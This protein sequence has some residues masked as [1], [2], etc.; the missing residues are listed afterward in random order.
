MRINVWKTDHEIADTVANSLE[1][2]LHGFTPNISIGY[3]ILRGNA[4]RI[5]ECETK[6]ESYFI[7][8]RGYFKP[9]H[10]DGY[11]RIS[12][13]G[14]QQTTGL[15]HIQP[16][17]ERLERLQID[18]PTPCTLT[19]DA[20]TL[21]VPP[22]E[23]A[24]EFFLGWD[25]SNEWQGGNAYAKLQQ[26]IEEQKQ[27]F[28]DARCIIRHKNDP[29]PLNEHLRNCLR[30]VTFNSSIGW[31]A[32]RR[33][34]AVYSDEKHSIVGAYQK[35]VD[36]PLHLD[37]QARRDLFAIMSSLQMTLEEIKT[38]GICK[39]VSQLLST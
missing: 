33:G 34:I 23:Y 6:N 20:H 31:E 5:K 39:L 25:L 12:L 27:K 3:G 30:V 21:I 15:A 11:Y 24:G 32:L 9:H 8:D 7:V 28:P 10:Y 17:Y 4:E 16:D 14:T 36:K 22:T 37:I 13:R 26:W 38:G 35:L 1:R 19:K 29:M 18:Y 2:G